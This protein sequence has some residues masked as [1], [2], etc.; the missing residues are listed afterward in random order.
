MTMPNFLVIGAQRSGTTSLYHYLRQHPQIYMPVLKE[1][2]F[3]AFYEEK[4]NFNSSRDPEASAERYQAIK[5]TAVTTLADYQ[6][7]FDGVTNEKS[8]GEVSPIYLYSPRAPINIK[9]F[10]PEAKLIVILRNPTDRAY[11]SI[12]LNQFSLN[13]IDYF[14]QAINDEDINS[15]N[16]WQG[17]RHHIRRG[18][19]CKQLKRYLKIFPYHDI[20]VHIFDD[21]KK[22]PVTFMKDIY[23]F[24]GVD[25][26]FEADTSIIHNKSILKS[27]S[28]F[29]MIKPFVPTFIKNKIKKY[30]PSQKNAYV[31]PLIPEEIRRTLYEIYREDILE[32]QDLIRRDLS[33]WQET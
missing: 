6:A 17:Y 20:K 18:F 21:L 12:F 13:P 33:M 5:R 8:I 19:Y 28:K 10:I 11:S 7:L 31:R 27:S 16:I 23:N 29:K 32:L 1:P 2:R 25:E 24:L 26:L 9:K 4:P 22:N 30:M 14:R 15:D 3:F